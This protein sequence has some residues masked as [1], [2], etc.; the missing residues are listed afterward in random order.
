MC[1]FKVLV[2]GKEVFHDVI[3][4]SYSGDRLLMTNV[5][6]EGIEL[7]D[8]IISRIDVE[9]EEIEVLQNPLVGGVLRFLVKYNEVKS[10]QSYDVELEGALEE[11]KAV[12]DQ[13]LRQ[14]WK[15]LAAKRRA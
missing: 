9:R 10:R 8:A 7:A 12:G 13:L 14:V 5:I 2:N 3:K 4:V 1:E 15:E 11:A 6:G